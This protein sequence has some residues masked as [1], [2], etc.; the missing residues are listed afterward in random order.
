M[1]GPHLPRD[2][3]HVRRY[4]GIIGAVVEAPASAP[5]PECGAPMEMH[6]EAPSTCGHFAPCPDAP[7]E[8]FAFAPSGAR[9]GHGHHCE[10]PPGHAGPCTTRGCGCG[11][12]ASAP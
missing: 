7:R 5:C 6:R 2:P 9:P 10:L 3:G 4:C 11:G 8:R 12:G 1:S